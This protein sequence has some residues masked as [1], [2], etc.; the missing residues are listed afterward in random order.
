MGDADP[1]ISRCSFL[2]CHEVTCQCWQV[3]WLLTNVHMPLSLFPPDSLYFVTEKDFSLCSMLLVFLLCLLWFLHPAAVDLWISDPREMLYFA[4]TCNF[5]CEGQRDKGVG[6]RGENRTGF[7]CEKWEEL[8]PE[9][10][11]TWVKHRQVLWEGWW[12]NMEKSP[13]GFLVLLGA[14]TACSDEVKQWFMH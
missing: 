5:P 2:H 13:W 6:L 12:G 10:F 3:T 11:T 8:L 4:Q 1:G 14:C 7:Y 9:P